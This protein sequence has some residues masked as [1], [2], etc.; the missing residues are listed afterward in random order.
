MRRSALG[1][2]AGLMFSIAGCG[3]STSNS[4]VCDN[5]ASALTNV[6]AKFAACGTVP[7]S[8]FDKNQCVNA[9]NNGGCTDADK[10]KINSF[11][12]CVNN[13]PNCTPATITAWETSFTGCESQLAGLSSNC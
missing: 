2:F 3:S 1:V 13:L 10:T 11:V 4:A 8:P 12:A 6:T 7:A 9:F 5:L